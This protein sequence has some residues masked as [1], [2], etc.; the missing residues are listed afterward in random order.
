MRPAARPSRSLREPQSTNSSAQ[1][2][3]HPH[4]NGLRHG[5]LPS[6]WDVEHAALSHEGVELLLLAWHAG[7]Q[8][9]NMPMKVSVALLAAEAQDVDPFRRHRH[10]AELFGL[11]RTTGF[12]LVQGWGWK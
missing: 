3:L 11:G 10:A 4:A 8:G 6:C 5:L 7:R 2:W 9:C 1:L 12:K